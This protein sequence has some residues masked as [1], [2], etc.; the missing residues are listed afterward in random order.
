MYA[1]VY[2]YAYIFVPPFFIE[3]ITNPKHVSISLCVCAFPHGVSTCICM[4]MY[5]CT[6]LYI[7][8]THTHLTHKNAHTHTLTD[9]HTKTCTYSTHT[10]M[11]HRGYMPILMQQP[12]KNIRICKPRSLPNKIARW[13]VRNKRVLHSLDS[14]HKGWSLECIA[15]SLH[16]TVKRAEDS[17]VLPRFERLCYDWDALL[18]ETC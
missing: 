13:G 9:T 15:P 3:C 6:Y 17:A 2:V 18:F 12:L 4:C 8:T 14:R 7:H 11:L 1:Y 5:V 16:I 10:G